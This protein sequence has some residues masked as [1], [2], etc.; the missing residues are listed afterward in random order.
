MLKFGAEKQNGTVTASEIRQAMRDGENGI[1]VPGVHGFF[2]IAKMANLS[3][4][5]TLFLLIKT[6][7]S[8]YLTA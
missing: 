7:F 8:S 1:G 6:A 5:C 3:Q 2:S 4:Y